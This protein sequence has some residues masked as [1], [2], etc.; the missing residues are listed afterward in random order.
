MTEKTSK[1]LSPGIKPA[2]LF[3]LSLLIYPALIYAQSG[4]SLWGH[5]TDSESGL[6]VEDAIVRLIPEGRVT[7]TDKD[8]IY[9]FFNL[10]YKSATIEIKAEGYE[11]LKRE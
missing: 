11:S 4:L 10:K 3:L 9:R 6:P 8:G 7:N 2:F 5:I 1:L